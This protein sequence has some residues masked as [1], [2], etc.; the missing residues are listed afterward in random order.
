MPAALDTSSLEWI[1]LDL[2]K[3]SLTR[4]LDREHF[5]RPPVNNKTSAR[6]LRSTAYRAVD[7]LLSPLNLA[8]VQ[9]TRTSRTGETMVGIGALDN[10]QELVV[11]VCEDGVPGDLV[12]TGIWRGGTVIFMRALLRVLGEDARSVWGFDSFEG[13]PRPDPARFPADEGDRLWSYSLDVSIDEVRENLRRYNM[14]D[15]RVHLVKGWFRDTI[16]TAEVGTIA[17]LR[18]DG[19]MYESTI[20]VL[21]GLYGRVAP[22]GYVIIDD[23]RAMPRCDQAVHDFRRNNGVRDTLVELPGNGAY[24]RKA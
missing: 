6:R 11:K 2:L 7:T 15:D 3:Q 12:E 18:L 14:L 23:Y 4:S 9:K 20:Q 24:W 22:G 19:D 16:P 8:L 21:D 5:R 10:V 17:V 1:Y 13:L